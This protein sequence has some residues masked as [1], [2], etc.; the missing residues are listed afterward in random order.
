MVSQE[1]AVT[2]RRGSAA[3]WVE[4]GN[5]VIKLSV[6]SIGAFCGLSSTRRG[7]NSVAYVSSGYRKSRDWNLQQI[8]QPRR[9][10]SLVI[11]G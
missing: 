4:L 6:E 5:D 1:R 10:F 8:G 9:I 2:P 11:R 3:G 7:V